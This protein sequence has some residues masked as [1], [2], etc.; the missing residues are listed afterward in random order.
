MSICLYVYDVYGFQTGLLLYK[1]AYNH[2]ISYD[3]KIVNS[4][5]VSNKIVFNCL[6]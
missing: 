2:S 3:N 1:L 6:F 5:I 4:L